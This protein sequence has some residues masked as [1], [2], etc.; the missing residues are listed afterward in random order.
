MPIF[1]STAI[2]LTIVIMIFKTPTTRGIT[3][4]PRHS[5]IQ[6]LTLL[7]KTQPFYYSLLVTAPQITSLLGRLNTVRQTTCC[8]KLTTVKSLFCRLAS[9]LENKSRWRWLKLRCK[10][11]KSSFNHWARSNKTFCNTRSKTLNRTLNISV[12]IR[13]TFMTRNSWVG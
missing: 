10:N 7:S 13:T 11:S 8:S 9:T 2:H 6:R 1:R 12:Q 3:R 4:Y 5:K